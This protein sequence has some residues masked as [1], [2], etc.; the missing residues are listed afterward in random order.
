MH[1]IRYHPAS[2]STQIR[3]FGRGATGHDSDQD[4]AHSGGSRATAAASDRHA[5]RLAFQSADEPSADFVRMI[6]VAVAVACD[7]QIE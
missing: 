3:Q 4:A 7:A 6:A 5:A 2:V 1:S